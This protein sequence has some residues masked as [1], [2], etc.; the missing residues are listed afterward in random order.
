M[1]AQ[2]LTVSIDAMGGDAGPGIVVAALARS[3]LR[4]P[5]VAYLLHGDEAVLKPLIALRARLHGSVALRHAP[6]RV[7]MHDKPRP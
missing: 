7:P 4:H 2:D 6:E 1:V 5:K 3:V